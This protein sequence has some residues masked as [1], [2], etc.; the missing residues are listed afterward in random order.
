L[1]GNPIDKSDRK[2]S[3]PIGFPI[4]NFYRI[5][6][7]ILSEFWAGILVWEFPNVVRDKSGIFFFGD[8]VNSLIFFF[9][10]EF[11]EKELNRLQGFTNGLQTRNV[12]QAVKAVCALLGSIESSSITDALDSLVELCSSLQLQSPTLYVS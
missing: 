11:L 4:G 8:C 5:L 10:L 3:Y 1:I 2:I 12:V 9:L 7:Y 6:S